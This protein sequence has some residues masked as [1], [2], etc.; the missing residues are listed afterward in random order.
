MWGKPREEVGRCRSRLGGSL[1]GGQKEEEKKFTR[2]F[3]VCFPWLVC[4]N[5]ST[6][7]KPRQ[8]HS[9]VCQKSKKKPIS[10]PLYVFSSMAPCEEWKKHVKSTDLL[11]CGRDGGQFCSFPALRPAKKGE[12][13]GSPPL[14]R[15]RA[16]VRMVPRAPGCR[17]VLTGMRCPAPHLGWE[18]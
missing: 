4:S 13:N 15:T 16:G 8:T 2:S 10:V 17:T 9:D 1:S 7:M 18:R 11:P 3:S 6:Q 5:S 12:D 14:I